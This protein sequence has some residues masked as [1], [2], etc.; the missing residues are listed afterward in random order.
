MKHPT[1]ILIDTAAT[2]VAAFFIAV[3][4]PLLLFVVIIGKAGDMTKNILSK[5]V[6]FED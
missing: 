1:N 2:I 6:E 5:I 3:A 4:V